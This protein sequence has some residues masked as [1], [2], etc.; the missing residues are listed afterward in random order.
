VVSGTVRVG[1]PVRVLPSGQESKVARI[2][3]F[4]GDLDEAVTLLLDE[5][6]R[7]NPRPVDE[8]GIRELLEDAYAGRRPGVVA[9]RRA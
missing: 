8:A 5:A 1:D 2:V 4:D 3:T 7:Q 9:K 6:P